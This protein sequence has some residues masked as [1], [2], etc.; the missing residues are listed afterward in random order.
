MTETLITLR[1]EKDTD[2]ARLRQAAAAVADVLGFG[3][4]TRTRVVTALIELARNALE[5]AGHGRARLALKADGNRL[6]LRAVVLDQGPG[7]AQLDEV[8]GGSDIAT[9]GLGLGLRG[10]RRIADSFDVQSSAEGTKVDVSF[11]SDLPAAGFSEAAGRVT[12]AL[13]GMEGADPSALLAEQ[14]RELLEAIEARDLLMQ[15]IH[16]RTGNNL[17]LIS[18]L[19]RMS[20]SSTQSPEA[21]QLLSE[22]D[23]RV[24]AVIKAHELMQHSNSGDMVPLL[25][26]LRDIARNAESAFNG[27]GLSVGVE[28]GGDELCVSGKTAVDLGLVVGELVTNAYKHAFT[29]RSQGKIQIELKCGDENSCL[30]IADDGKGLS[31][32]A[33]RPERSNSLGWRLIRTIAQQYGGAIET[34]GENGLSVSICFS[35]RLV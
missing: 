14:N 2:I 6:A 28:V 29:G 27:A 9:H 22:L 4:F 25:P 20:G 13:S 26:F 8:L 11:R 33:E 3:T 23:T 17:T 24:R 19:I 1:I 35:E 5:Y 7:I 16:H 15:E 34:N 32:G 30:T 12:E 18:A 21:K 31:D 10:V